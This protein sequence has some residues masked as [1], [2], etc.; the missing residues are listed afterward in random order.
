MGLQER[1]T[2]Y[3]LV[4]ITDHDDPTYDINDCFPDFVVSLGLVKNGHVIYPSI[5]LKANRL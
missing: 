5:A 1:V 4:K 2:I 3:D